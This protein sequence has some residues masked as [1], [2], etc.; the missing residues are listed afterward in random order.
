MDR[1]AIFILSALLLVSTAAFA[2]EKPAVLEC[3]PGIAKLGKSL[4]SMVRSSGSHRRHLYQYINENILPS[5]SNEPYIRNTG[6][7]GHQERAPYC[8]LPSSIRQISRLG[9]GIRIQ[10][11]E[12]LKPVSKIKLCVAWGKIAEDLPNCD[13]RANEVFLNEVHFAYA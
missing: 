3:L 8:G 13:S 5:I 9:L 1:V 4:G 12:R 11:A 2:F 10:L 6:R 7:T